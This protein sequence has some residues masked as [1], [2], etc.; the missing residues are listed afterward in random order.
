MTVTADDQIYTTDGSRLGILTTD[1][2]FRYCIIDRDTLLP[3]PE[4]GI[5]NIRQIKSEGE[6]IYLNINGRIYF[7]SDGRIRL[8][9][10]FG[11][12]AELKE[13][14]GK[15]IAS[16]PAGTGFTGS[17]I[18]QTDIHSELSYPALFCKR[19]GGYLEYDL[20]EKTFTALND[21]LE[22]A[23]IWKAGTESGIIDMIYDEN[24][25]FFFLDENLS[26]LITDINGK[27]LGQITDTPL[28]KNSTSNHFVRSPYGQIWL[29]QDHSI[30]CIDYPCSFLQLAEADNQGDIEDFLLYKDTLYLAT[31]K[32]LFFYSEGWKPLFHKPVYKL[33]SSGNN[34]YALGNDELYVV[35]GL[36]LSSSPIPR[37]RDVI[38][39]QVSGNLVMAVDSGFRIIKIPGRLPPEV[40][41]PSTLL[42]IK[43]LSA[44]DTLYYISGN[45][46][47]KISITDGIDRQ[48]SL[49]RS[50]REENIRKMVWWQNKVALITRDKILTLSGN[51]VKSVYELRDDQFKDQII[52][53]VVLNQDEIAL[54]E[55][56]DWNEG[57]LVVYNAVRDTSINVPV[58]VRISPYSI[59]VRGLNDSTLIFSDNLNIYL[60]KTTLPAGA[61]HY[62]PLII[63][64]IA[65]GDTILSNSSYEAARPLLHD[66]LNNIPY[67]NNDLRVFFST[68]DYVPGLKK[69]QYQINASGN[70]WSDWQ[71][72]NILKLE[73]L[74]EGDYILKTRFINNQGIISVPAELHFTVNPPLMLTWY[75]WCAYGIVGFIIFFVLYKSYRFR[76]HKLDTLPSPSNTE[77]LQKSDSGSEN[78]AYEFITTIEPEGK[79]KKTKWD[80]Y[81]MATVLFSDIQGF[82]KIAEQMNPER[83]ID[84]LDTFF[85]H[86]DS[87]V[88]KYNI[89]KI[90]TIGDAYMAA[91]GIPKKNSTNPIE[92]V[93]AALEMQQYMMHL[94]KLNIDIWD[95]RI[96]IH[97]GP[98]IAG[99]IGQKK[100]SYDIWGDTVNTAS[101][102]ESSGSPGKVNIS[103]M[104]FNLIKDYFICEYRGKIPVKY[105]GNIDMYF[106]KGL[107]PE[108][109]INLAGIP[110]RKFFLKLQL[111][112]L[113]D[114]EDYTYDR[115]EVELPANVYFH[116]LNYAKQIY[117]HA[118]LLCKAEDLDLEEALMIRT[119]TLLLPLG[120][121]TSYENPEK[122]AAAIATEILPEY[123]YSEKQTNLITNLILSTKLPA[124]PRNLLEKIMA[125]TRME[126]LGRI[127]FIKLYKLLFL[128]H[129]EFHPPVEIREWKEEQINILASHEFFTE[130]ARRLREVSAAEQ[131]KKIEEDDL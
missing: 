39:D 92:V 107:R 30:Y 85:F 118:G 64:I 62:Y 19:P 20:G 43:S 113:I 37:L 13:T 22:I 33:L 61:K 51:S 63:T 48:V 11:T 89:E 31:N 5:R 111:Q 21:N 80:K 73:D 65:G 79:M 1:T 100:R 4:N 87:V 27:T 115:L 26:I 126:Y 83:L 129:N 57:E 91:G 128:E 29:V 12:G 40:F 16:G 101:R 2:S 25:H 106:V 69:Y 18:G 66:K 15:L 71:L 52:D 44:G 68:T 14:G 77:T 81:E 41:L 82:T 122:Q 104:T 108:L 90:K 55:K 99:T 42:P 53:A 70:D 8:L 112:R 114:L 36:S 117:S 116:N 72:G 74:R 3:D 125:D 97:S 59:Q 105:K 123:F 86:F 93:L 7:L 103:G 75:A 120:Y 94:K 88:E 38:L 47:H 60:L 96:G 9:P 34:L 56:N 23:G 127:D 54:I 45:N 58:P 109:S 46:I 131:I 50:I 95:L 124:S 84:E 78:K 24:G 98:V 32:G 10:W 67:R 49:P 121:I 28:S 35:S 102:M 130:G 17:T 6:Q 76:M 110:N 119:A